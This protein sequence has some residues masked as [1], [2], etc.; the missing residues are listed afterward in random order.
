VEIDS[1]WLD[2]EYGFQ[3][4]LTDMGERPAGTSIGRYLDSGSYTKSNCAW[5]TDAEQKSEARGKKA[6]LALRAWK[7]QFEAVTA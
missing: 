1:R 4:F 6:M 2:K 5:Q 3:N 7:H